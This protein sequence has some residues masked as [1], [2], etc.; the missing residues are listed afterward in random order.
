MRMM[1]QYGCSERHV[2]RSQDRYLPGALTFLFWVLPN[3]LL[4]LFLLHVR[5]CSA[6]GVYPGTYSSA[7]LRVLGAAWLQEFLSLNLDF[8]PP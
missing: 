6:L 1:R 4:A 2:G 5:S 8:G 7:A 3:L